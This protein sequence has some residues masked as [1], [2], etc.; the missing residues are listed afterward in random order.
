[1]QPSTG[2]GPFTGV[3]IGYP[4]PPAV[5]SRAGPDAAY[6]ARV[7]TAES[8]PLSPSGRRLLRYAFIV[9]ALFGLAIGLQAMVLHLTTDPFADT[10][11]YY[12]AGTRLNEG[13]PL[14]I[15]ST[16]EGIGPY[17]NPPLLAI[18]FRPLALLPFPV[19]AAIWQ[20]VIT[21]AFVLTVRRIGLREP[22]LDRHR[23]PRPADPVGVERRPGRARRHAD[24]DAGHA[25]QRRGR[26]QPQA[27]ARA[28]RRLLDRPAGDPPVAAPRCL[29]ARARP[30]PARDRAGG[31]PR[32]HP[33]RVA[34]RRVRVPQH[35][36]VRHPPGPVGRD[37][38]RP[39]RR[40]RCATRRP[41]TDGRSPSPCPCS[42][43][44]ASSSTSC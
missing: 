9:I 37:R 21:A 10:R 13:Q 12:D 32:V 26:R 4:D 35:L 7:L 17:V 15:P 6:G 5:A 28:G 33:S 11:L 42:P 41:D 2:P 3:R 38:R 43:I 18:L 40:W 24:A 27:H 44:L 36:A 16:T 34:Q 22:V 20:V 19:A 25:R 8:M 30:V 23:L 14:Y 39:R 31:D 1:M 29:A